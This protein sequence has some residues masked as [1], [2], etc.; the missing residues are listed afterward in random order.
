MSNQEKSG[1]LGGLLGMARRGGR[2]T[3]GFNAVVCLIAKSKSVMLMLATDLSE[4]TEKELRFAARS[5]N[6]EIIRLPLSKEEIG[7]ALGLTKPVGVLA[8]EDEGFAATV[9]LLCRD[10]G[11]SKEE[12][13]VC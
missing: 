10:E 13:T 6:H 9:R 8:L 4:K 5:K 2:L 1:R 7:Q 11:D 12:F 3:T